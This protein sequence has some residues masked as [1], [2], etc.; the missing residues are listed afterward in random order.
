[1]SKVKKR[2]LGA[3]TV[4]S[5]SD[6]EIIWKLILNQFSERSWENIE[7]TEPDEFDLQMIKE[8]NEN[9]DCKKFVN[10]KDINW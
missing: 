1:M 10:A 6:A 3:L 2:I 4:M 9:P 7:E 8:I 5:D